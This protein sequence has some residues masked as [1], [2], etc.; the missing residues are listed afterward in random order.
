MIGT[1]KL[2]MPA[3]VTKPELRN[4]ESEGL[5]LYY[6]YNFSPLSFVIT[7]LL[8][9]LE[10]FSLLLQFVHAYYATSSSISFSLVGL[11]AL[12]SWW[13][14][15]DESIPHH[16]SKVTRS[17]FRKKCKTTHFTELASHRR[18]CVVLCVARMRN[19]GN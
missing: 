12:S 8:S 15:A 10:F 7:A 16:L 2:F 11:R 19:S 9:N 13:R 14:M 5:K 6:D 18:C 4:Q 17:K 1:S 3:K